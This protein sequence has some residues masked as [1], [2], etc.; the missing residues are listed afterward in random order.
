MKGCTGICAF[1]EREVTFLEYCYVRVSIV[2]H[3]TVEVECDP[4]DTGVGSLK[5]WF[6]MEFSSTNL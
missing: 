2:L 5:V 1:I 6:V 4:I 3:M